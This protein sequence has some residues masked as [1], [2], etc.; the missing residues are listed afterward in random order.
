MKRPAALRELGADVIELDVR[1]WN[2]EAR[3]VYE[4]WGFR[5]SKL[6]LAANAEDLEARLSQEGPAPSHGLVFA[7]TDDE[8]HVAKAVHAYM[9]RLGRLG[10]SRTRIR[11]PPAG[12]R[13]TTSYAAA[14]RPCSAAS[15][16]SS[17]TARV[18]LC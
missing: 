5:E 14:T 3:T 12:S 18:A 9:P 10:H 15:R 6:T 17:P 11:P 2:E 13:W 7:Q 8:S 1:P 16:R 4:R